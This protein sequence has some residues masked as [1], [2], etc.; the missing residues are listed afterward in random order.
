VTQAGLLRSTAAAQEMHMSHKFKVQQR[1]RLTRPV[2]SSGRS[3]G[4][5]VY[6]IVRLLPADQTGEPAYRIKSSDGEWAVVESE[7]AMA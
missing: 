7:L 2:F 4:G 6:E 5:G 3:S 1:V